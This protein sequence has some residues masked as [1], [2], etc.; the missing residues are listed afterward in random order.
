M[1]LVPIRYNLRSLFVRWSSTVLTVCAVGATIAVFAGMLSMQQGF[2]TLFQEK[3][4]DD[5]AVFLRQGATSEGE[6]GI[7]LEQTEILKKEVPEVERNRQG[8]PLASAELYLA[9]RLRKF[10]GGETNVAIR[11]VEPMTFQIHGDD[12][13]IVDGQNFTPGSDELI[14]GEG[15]LGRIA[16]C[17]VGDTLRINT[18]TFRIVGTFAAKGGYRSEIW[19]DLER[20]AEALERPV[21]SRVLAKVAPGTDLQAIEDRYADD[22]RLQPKVLSEKDYLRSQTSDLSAR[23]LFVGAFLAIIMGIGAVFTGTNSMLAAIGARTHEIGILKAIGYKPWAIFLAFVG[24]SLLL[25]LLGGVAGC[26]MVLP[27]QGLE[28][29]T[30]NST[31]SEVTFAFRTTPT[32]LFVSI[33][34]AA[35]LGLVG[36][37]FPAWRA[38][39]MTPTQALRRG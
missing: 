7:T 21:R 23:F 10:D 30:V 13:R 14:V 22:L 28:T 6:S 18:G 5:L 36:G 11:G 16:N 31:F 12:V 29:G 8:Q 4:R 1:A 34:F 35:L 25:G 38:S 19:G 39:R 9:V 24:E 20:L 2:A 32:A 17:N 26:L 37:L 3:G 15:L 27:F 33:A